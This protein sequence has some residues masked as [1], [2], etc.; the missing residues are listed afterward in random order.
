MTDSDSIQSNMMV[1]L[2]DIDDVPS[3]TPIAEMVKVTVRGNSVAVGK[4]LASTLMPR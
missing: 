1:T 2:N 4:T 3:S